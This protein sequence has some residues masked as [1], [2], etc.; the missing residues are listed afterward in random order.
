MSNIKQL[1]IDVL[2]GVIDGLEKQLE[3]AKAELEKLKGG[4]GEV[5]TDGGGGDPIPPDPT[6]PHN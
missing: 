3:K 2:E 4:D 1:A 5:H 6:H